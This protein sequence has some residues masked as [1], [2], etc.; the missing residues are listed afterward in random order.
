LHRLFF[1]PLSSALCLLNTG[2]PK[3]VGTSISCARALAL[4]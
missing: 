1:C 3:H 4:L 2:Q